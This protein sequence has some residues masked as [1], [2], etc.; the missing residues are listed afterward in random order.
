MIKIVHGNL[1]KADVEALVNTVNTEGVMGKGI[2][3]QFKRAYPA[4]YQQYRDACQRNAVAVGTMHVVDLGG[5]GGGPRW[6]VNFPTKRHWKSKSKIEDIKAGLAALRDTIDDL[7]I[8]SIA[9]PPLGCGNGGLEWAAVEP[10][11]HSELGSIEGVRVEVFAPDGAPVASEMPNRTSKPK[12]TTGMAAVVTLVDN[13]RR[14]L[15]E[16]FVRLVEVHKLMYFLQEAGEPLRLKYEKGLYGPYSTNLRHVLDRMEGHY[17]HGFGD[18]QDTPT[19]CIDVVAGSEDVAIG[20]LE[21]AMATH[22]R[23]ERVA[24]LIEGFED[25]FG[26]ELLGSVHWIMMTRPEAIRSLDAAITCVHSWNE[27]KSNIM[28]PAHI[29]KAWHRLKEHSW[30]TEARSASH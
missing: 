4:A 7:G 28:K 11:I 14:G 29:A 30:D 10:L 16:P 5:M 15:M 21:G 12:M 22:A 24:A 23:M 17:I 18:G 6:I 2:A 13:Y 19:K 8:R 27:R 9:V 25:P 1:L 26:M 20:V 3:L